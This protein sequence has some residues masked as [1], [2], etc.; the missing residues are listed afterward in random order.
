M[1][2]LFVFLHYFVFWKTKI[3][4]AVS[5]KR[6]RVRLEDKE[7]VKLPNLLVFDY[8]ESTANYSMILI[9]DGLGEDYLGINLIVA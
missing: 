9:L 5:L 4:I 3:I 6:D 2:F 7:N 8:E 1:I